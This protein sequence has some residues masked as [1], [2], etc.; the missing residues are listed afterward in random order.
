MK[1]ILKSIVEFLGF[2]GDCIC[3][4]YYVFDNGQFKPI[5][6]LEY[7]LYL[8]GFSHEKPTTNPYATYLCIDNNSK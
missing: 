6:K 2:A 4:Q 8:R 7:D 1:R 3:P 5:T